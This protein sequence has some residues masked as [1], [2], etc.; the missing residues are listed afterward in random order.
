MCIRDSGSR[1]SEHAESYVRVGDVHHQPVPAYARSP[2]AGIGCVCRT[3]STLV[4]IA[5]VLRLRRRGYDQPTLIVLNCK[6]VP[7]HATLYDSPEPAWSPT[8]LGG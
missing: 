3:G 6:Y 2:V 8:R 7:V 1:A 4:R 5:T